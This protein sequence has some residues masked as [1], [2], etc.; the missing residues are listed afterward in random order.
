MKISQ[1]QGLW[2]LLSL[3]ITGAFGNLAYETVKNAPE[4][5]LLSYLE[6]APT[7]APVILGFRELGQYGGY[8]SADKEHLKVWKDPGEGWMLENVAANKRVDARTSEFDTRYLRRISLNKGDKLQFNTF[9]IEVKN[10]D[11][12]YLELYSPTRDET[13]E[14][15]NGSFLVNN[16]QGFDACDQDDLHKRLLGKGADWLAWRSRN[17]IVFPEKSIFLFSLGGQVH[18]TTRW[19]HADTEPDAVRFYWQHNRFW[20]AMGG[21]PVR[22]SVERAGKS[23]ELRKQALAISGE[24]GDVQRLILGRTHYL[25]ADRDGYLRFNPTTNQPVF[26][27]KSERDEVTETERNL[28]Q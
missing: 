24:D 18:C 8:N 4:V 26:I 28:I 13:A 11:N 22:V 14:W 20:M 5:S 19:N 25:I 17:W 15:K 6:V 27:D 21:D 12:Q 23:L 1:T 2:F 7:Q 9:T 3:M 10:V 16:K